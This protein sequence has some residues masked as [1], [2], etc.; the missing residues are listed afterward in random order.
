MK[1]RM[2]IVGCGSTGGLMK[3]FMLG[4]LLV[5]A[6]AVPSHALER[7]DNCRMKVHD[8]SKVKVV[9]TMKDGGQ[10]AVC[11]LYCA[12]MELEREGAGVASVT[13]VDYVT[14]EVLT[15]SDAAWVEGSDAKAVMSDVSR[16]AFKDKSA[17]EAF[18]KEHG[19]RVITYD[20]ALAGSVSEW[21]R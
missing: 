7:C 9:V 19:G 10:H 14:G 1:R 11:G 8:E 16:I 12:S 15:A 4:M 13:T 2:A 6:M 5:A 20:E 3:R 17:A 18:V 21:K